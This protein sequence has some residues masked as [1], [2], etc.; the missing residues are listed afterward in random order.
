MAQHILKD[1]AV[2]EILQLIERIDAAGQRND[3]LARAVGSANLDRKFLPWNQAAL[4][5]AQGN[6]L[7]ALQ[8]KD[9]QEVPSSKTSGITPMPTR[10]ER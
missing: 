8:S 1:S 5:P 9:R 4:D 10:L 2:A 3:G 6:D 7:V